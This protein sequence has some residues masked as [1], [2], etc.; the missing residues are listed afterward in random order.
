MRTAVDID[1]GLA[2]P[3]KRVR[4][5]PIW[6]TTAA[7]ALVTALFIYA[8]FILTS[9]DPGAWER[10]SPHE[11][12]SW[13]VARYQIEFSRLRVDL[14]LAGRNKLASTNL[15][16]EDVRRRLA[17]LKTIGQAL[18]ARTQ[19]PGT[20]SDLATAVASV[21][22]MQSRVERVIEQPY[23]DG[24]RFLEA[25][26][27]L[28]TVDSRLT[29]IAEKVAQ[30][31]ATL[32]ANSMR[33][34]RE[35]DTQKK[36]MLFVGW[37]LAVSIIWLTNR[38]TRTKHLQ[39][40]QEIAALQAQR[41]I[42]LEKDAALQQKALFINRVGHELRSSAQIFGN[43]VDNLEEKCL[44]PGSVKALNRIK[45]AIGSIV[46]QLHDIETIDR[47]EVGMLEIHPG[48]FEACEMLEELVEEFRSAA[49]DKDLQLHIIVPPMKTHVVSD[50]FRIRQILTNL[51]SNAIKYTD[52]GTVTVTL[53]RFDPSVG[54]LCYSVTDTGPGIPES[55]KDSIFEPFERLG[56]ASARVMSS[57]IGLTVAQTVAKALGATIRL[58]S[59]VGFGTKFEVDVP[60]AQQ[61]SHDTVGRSLVGKVLFVDDRLDLLEDMVALA[62][63]A[64]IDAHKASSAAL[65]SVN[66][67][68]TPYDVV[69][70]D[71]DMPG[72]GGLQLAVE[73][74]NGKGLNKNASLVAF[75]ASDGRNVGE[76]YP[77]DKFVAK[78]LDRGDLQKLVANPPRG[79]WRA[80]QPTLAA[81]NGA[82]VA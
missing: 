80:K 75:S 77:F 16:T 82:R 40:K 28:E 79:A 62:S 14:H 22:D 5:H 23:S 1:L 50:V 48:P 53:K 32:R 60:A 68:T 30:A 44:D 49:L 69:F 36:A 46:H 81:V 10:N 8:G 64:Q 42:V 51:L 4:M 2:E 29:A 12:Y 65:A 67:A 59:V 9:S 21:L 19:V 24:T 56:S 13:T 33:A 6:L 52:S 72:K 31:E 35:R 26:V 15:A 17:S 25:L 39:Q 70:I 11:G 38:L 73:T 20:P 74:R 27:E 43:S 47:G 63:K 78:P 3:N 57:G 34:L 66:L 76:A 71:L 58:N 61:R 37:I 18:T 54:K 45:R 41:Q 7:I 55:G